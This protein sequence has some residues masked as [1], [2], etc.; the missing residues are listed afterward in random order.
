MYR[1]WE[2]GY[3]LRSLV[4]TNY[5][6]F[7][8]RQGFHI[9]CRSAE[10]SK[11]VWYIYISWKETTLIRGVINL[12]LM[13]FLSNT[14]HFNVNVRMCC[15][16]H[17]VVNPAWLLVCWPFTEYSRLQPSWSMPP[18]QSD[19]Q[20]GAETNFKLTAYKKFPTNYPHWNPEQWIS[21]KRVDD[22]VSPYWRVHNKLYDLTDF[23]D[24]HPGGIMWN[25][26]TLEY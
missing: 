22:N 11:V 16:I 19:R 6:I 5:T 4:G 18:H 17:K 8:N 15:R 21:G 1:W 24:R 20:G 13:Q 10:F 9:L 25:I 26:L 23:L 2:Q 7:I 12:R 3:Y 14:N